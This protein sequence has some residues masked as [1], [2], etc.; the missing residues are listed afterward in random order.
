[1]ADVASATMKSLSPDAFLKLFITQLKNQD[2]DSPLDTSQMTAQLA[3]LTTVQ[4]LTDM[5]TNFSNVMKVEQLSLAKGLI[6]SPVT[7]TSGSQQ[8]T[9]Q[10]QSAQISDGVV[11]VTVDGL[12]VK[13]DDIRTIG[14]GSAQ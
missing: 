2:P 6:G 7:Y 10:V 3:Q 4:K 9:G 12:F 11:G 14:S 8:L 13:L 1:M 5:S